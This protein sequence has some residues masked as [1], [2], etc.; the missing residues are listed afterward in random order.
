MRRK[1]SSEAGEAGD[2]VGARGTVT[3]GNPASR[4]R[5]PSRAEAPGTAARLRRRLVVAY[6]LGALA[7]AIAL[8]A[9]TFAATDDLPPTAF[10][11]FVFVYVFAWPLA[12]TLA[13]L[14]GEPRFGMARLGLAYL[15]SGG[16][17][18][19]GWSLV[20]RF[21]LGRADVEP[22]QNLRFCAV[23]LV[24]TAAAPLAIV[25]ISGTRRV[26]PVVPLALA[27]LLVFSFA[28]L[29]VQSAFIRAIDV[30]PLRAALLRLGYTP[31]FLLASLPVGLLCWWAQRW[32]GRRYQAKRFSDVQLLVDTWWVIAVFDACANLATTMGWRALWVLA[33]FAAY[34]AVV[35]AGL[36]WQAV[37]SRQPPPARLLLLRVFGA[38][39]RAERLFDVLASDWRF[40]GNVN[41]IAG[42]DLAVRTIDPGDILA[43]VGGD[44]RSQFVRDGA[45]LGRR[46]AA[47]DER[48]D[49]DGRFRVNDFFCFDDTWRPTLE[50]LLGRSDVVLM[51]LRGVSDRNAGCLFEMQQLA[52][53]AMLEKALFVVDNDEEE[54]LLRATVAQASSGVALSHEPTL[55]IVRVRG[56]SRAELGSIL[57]ALRAR[58]PAPPTPLPG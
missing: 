31:L 45:D 39:R 9:V 58:L 49:P 52:A 20:S 4:P 48:R 10:R 21:V 32:L 6:V 5:A 8:T 24:M 43:L 18:V 44:L 46:L 25:L 37:S 2:A 35:S 50:S 14:L 33:A 53:R 38:P 47:L 3:A 16:A 41:L 36:A 42:A 51:D 56:N 30:V 13:A 1:A 22:L 28:A 55:G 11:V 19:L 34:R 17:I 12:P 7:V 40:R 29:L 15:L 27:G 54:R 23:F 26:G 57:A